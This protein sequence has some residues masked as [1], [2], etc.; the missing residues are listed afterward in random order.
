MEPLKGILWGFLD[1]KTKEMWA[2]WSLKPTTGSQQGWL[3]TSHARC[4]TAFSPEHVINEYERF[5][6]H[7]LWRV[8]LGRRWNINE[9]QEYSAFFFYFLLRSNDWKMEILINLNCCF[10]NRLQCA[11]QMDLQWGQKALIETLHTVTFM[12]SIPSLKS[13]ITEECVRYRVLALWITKRSWMGRPAVS[14]SGQ[15]QTEDR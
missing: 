7:S 5:V 9:F 11:V 15:W 14:Q 8:R 1:I 10:S 12:D 6:E 13:F 4:S 2:C 3:P